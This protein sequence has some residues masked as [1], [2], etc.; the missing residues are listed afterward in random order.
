[1]PGEA[2]QW[3]FWEVAD[4]KDSTH[5]PHDGLLICSL[6]LSEIECLFIT[7]FCLQ[8][9]LCTRSLWCLPRALA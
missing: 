4:D 8:L 7:H 3:A 5:A 1:M 9:C 2:E 6:W